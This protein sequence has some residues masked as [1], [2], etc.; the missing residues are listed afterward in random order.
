MINSTFITG[1][2]VHDPQSKELPSGTKVC[3]FRLANSRKYT[4]NSGNNREET[5][6][7][8]VQVFGKSA[9]H[10]Q[11]FLRNGSQVLV[12]G[13]LQQRDYQ[14][15]DGQNRSEISI[16]ADTV[17]FLDGK[18]QQQSNRL[19]DN[20]R[21]DYATSPAQAP[22][23]RGGYNYASP[24]PGEPH[25]P[26]SAADRPAPRPPVTQNNEDGIPF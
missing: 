9:T 23:Q 17:Q 16:L 12:Q 18:P 7:I 13:R 6:F 24:M 21:N 25:S 4:D 11:Q 2:L 8:G 5:L 14:T 10:C 19:P 1:N 15:R 3:N 20:C 26:Y 22:Q